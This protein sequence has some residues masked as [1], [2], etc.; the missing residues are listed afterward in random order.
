VELLTNNLAEK[1]LEKIAKWVRWPLLLAAGLATYTGFNVWKDV[2]T[3]IETFQ[4]AADEKLSQIDKNANERLAK[5]LEKTLDAR[6]ARLGQLTDVLR[7]ES[8]A[9]IVEAERARAASS[10]S[11]KEIEKQS[12]DAISLVKRQADA[13]I[14]E[15]E[16]RLREVNTRG[17][18]VLMAIAV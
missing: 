3:R 4:K 10:E 12:K 7:K 1:T 14:A 2:T 11:S 18:S 6:K 15:L 17:Q 13:T 16:A 5:E 9:A 8:A